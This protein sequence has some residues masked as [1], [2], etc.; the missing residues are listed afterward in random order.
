MFNIN[1]LK[2]ALKKYNLK[3]DIAENGRIAIEK[4][5]NYRS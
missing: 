2:L 1:A 4:I 3:I 5:I